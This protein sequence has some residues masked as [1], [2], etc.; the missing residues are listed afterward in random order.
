MNLA[1]NRKQ[2]IPDVDYYFKKLSEITFL[3]IIQEIE[4]WKQP[5]LLL[6]LGILLLKIY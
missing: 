6:L 2:N 3:L 5:V 1:S 4:E